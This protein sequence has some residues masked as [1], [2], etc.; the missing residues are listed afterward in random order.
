VDGV[1]ADSNHGTAFTQRRP[2][3]PRP[4]ATVRP[5]RCRRRA[6]RPLLRPARS[7]AWDAQTRTLKPRTVGRTFEVE[8]E[9]AWLHARQR[10]RRSTSR[11]RRT[12]EA[13][14]T[15]PGRRCGPTV[16]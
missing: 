11:E 3:R 5:G 15:V 13:T 9:A 7:H 6:R 12:G 14:G 16:T 1:L 4:A 10:C 2:G 8:T